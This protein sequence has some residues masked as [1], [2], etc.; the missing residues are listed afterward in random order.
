MET[1]WAIF[2]ATPKNRERTPSHRADSKNPHAESCR[3]NNGRIADIA[4]GCTTHTCRNYHVE[5]YALFAW[6]HRSIL[7]RFLPECK[8][9]GP[10]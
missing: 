2:R 9:F 6:S 5:L 8:G 10:D 4:F 3:R 7:E 1:N